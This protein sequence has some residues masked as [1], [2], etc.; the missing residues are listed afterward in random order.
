MLFHAAIVAGC[1]KKM[2]RL[3][4][5][6]FKSRVQQSVIRDVLMVIQDPALRWYANWNKLCVPSIKW[7]SVWDDHY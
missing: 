6:T 4:T 1:R 2:H 3:L 5:V 7:C